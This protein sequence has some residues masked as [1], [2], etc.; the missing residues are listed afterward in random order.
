MC[1]SRCNYD[2]IIIGTVLIV[3][4]YSLVGNQLFLSKSLCASF[5][6][7][8]NYPGIGDVGKTSFTSLTGSKFLLKP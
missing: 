1:H 2:P 5:T 6:P 4:H 3:I 7:A 8:D